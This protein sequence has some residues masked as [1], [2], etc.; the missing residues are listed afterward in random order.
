MPKLSAGVL[1]YRNP[2]DKLEVL[3]VHPGGPFWA[4]KNEG[5]WSIPK[6]EYNDEDPLSAAKREF[7]E[8][9]GQSPPK[10][11]YLE[12]GEAKAS[13]KINKIWAVNGDLDVTKIK[14][15]T[16]ELEWPPRSGRKQEFPEIDKAEWFDL[17]V[18]KRKLRTSQ[19]EFLDRLE[20][21]LGLD[22]TNTVPPS[23]F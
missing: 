6:G 8:E 5:T 22:P 17:A 13:N 11:E 19:L 2:E 16:F 9:L 15:N 7:K 23:L 3:L 21:L 20:K 18:A 4:N 12:L 1:V 10:G 14:S